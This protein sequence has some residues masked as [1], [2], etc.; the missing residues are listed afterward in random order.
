MRAR[1]LAVSVSMLCVGAVLPGESQASGLRLFQRGRYRQA[2]ACVIPV[3]RPVVQAP[4]PREE[5]VTITRVVPVTTYR[6]VTRTETYTYT[7]YVRRPDGSVVPVR[8]TAQRRVTR[9]EPVTEMRTVTSQVPASSPEGLRAT[10]QLL[11]NDL[12]GLTKELDG[13]NKGVG[14]RPEVIKTIQQQIDD[15]GGRLPKTSP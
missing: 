10:L 5:M 2:P 7:E 4:Q 12:N 1:W 3:S 13:L 14:L 15:I 11:Q 8:R 6:P 9:M